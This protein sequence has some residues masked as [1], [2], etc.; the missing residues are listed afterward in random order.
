MRRARAAPNSAARARAASR[1]QTTNVGAR[2]ARRAPRAG[3][4]VAR[5]DRARPP[6][7]RP[8]PSRRA[9]RGA[10]RAR[11]AHVRAWTRRVAHVPCVSTHPGASLPRRQHGAPALAAPP[12]PPLA[13]APGPSPAPAAPRRAHASASPPPPLPPP[14][15]PPAHTMSAVR[16]VVRLARLALL[17]LVACPIA[18]QRVSLPLQVSPPR[19]LAAPS[20]RAVPHQLRL[21]E[22]GLPNVSRPVSVDLLGGITAV[23]EYYTRILVGG[24]PIRVQIDTGSSTLALPV[25]GCARCLPTDQRYNPRV[26]NSQHVRT[27]SCVHQ[28]CQPDMCSVHHCGACSATDA[29]CA[30]HNEQACA[31]RLSYGDGSYARGELMI[32]TLT[33]G[34]VSAPVVF[35]GILDDSSD[36]QRDMVDGILGMAY[37]SLACNPTCV[38]PPL[39]QMV[40]AGVI[41]DS[42][43]ICVTARGGRLILGDYDPSLGTSPPKYVPLALSDPPSYYTMN[44]SNRI[45]VGD[46]QLNV[47]NLRSGI[48]DS[49][50]T[51]VVVSETTFILMLNHMM[52][53]HCDVEGMCEDPSWFMPSVCTQ[54][55]DED[56]EKMPSFVFH[57]GSNGEFD[58]E[59]RPSDYM[60][61]LNKPGRAGYRCVG[62]MAMKEMQ[63]GTDIIFGNTIMQRY[64]THYDRQNKRLGFAESVPDCGAVTNCSSYT[65]C[66][67]CAAAASHCAFDYRSHTCHE[68]QPT[69]GI[70]PYPR[71]TGTA[72]MCRLG[73]QAPLVFGVVAGLVS[74]LVTGLLTLLVIVLY[75][76]RGLNAAMH[77]HP[78]AYSLAG[79]DDL[80]EDQDGS[81]DQQFVQPTKKYMPVPTE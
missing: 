52:Q 57:L 71:C 42:F 30:E 58:M 49:G 45:T 74:A 10:P 17:A 7:L 72:C 14:P 77:E 41:S 34:N 23:G 1:R 36:F 27:V 13:R 22:P 19:K 8:A 31:F 59:L 60:L 50:T 65:Q 62:F 76:R 70:V 80:D 55:S 56:L 61:P 54:L 38:E 46:R 81:D 2:A 63:D 53:H 3:R 33:W 11:A 47:P 26:S 6:A 64:V 4:R 73:P 44:V 35:G 28:L 21:L 32:D 9:R 68:S 79:G 69:L 5:R 12:S 20:S 48:L 39:Q 15:P 78:P 29:C 43:S 25:A 18:A 24:Q 51:L 66:R 67:E 40:K 75:S 37:K 16:L